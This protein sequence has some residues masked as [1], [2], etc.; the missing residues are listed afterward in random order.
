MD[1]YNI[2]L[3]TDI[4]RSVDDYLTLAYLLTKD[5]CNL[6]GVIISGSNQNNKAKIAS[7]VCTSSKKQ[8]P[9]YLGMDSKLPNNWYLAPI[10][11][12]KLSNWQ[13][14]E[15]FEGNFVDYMYSVIKNNPYAITIIAVGQLTSIAKL[16]EIYPN[17]TAYIKELRIMG[18]V[19]DKELKTSSEMPFI[20]W[21]IWSDPVSAKKV[22]ASG[23]SIIKVYGYEITKDLT[24]TK[25]EFLKR[26]NTDLFKCVTDFS[27][28][29]LNTNNPI[30]NDCLPAVSVFND[31]MCSYKKG[32]IEINLS[33]EPD[34]PL[35]G[36]TTFIEK[37]S[38][39]IELC[40]KVEKDKFFIEYFK[41]IDKFI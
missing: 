27:E 38:G 2:L 17:C 31:E 9:I 16:I 25:E 11:E 15:T 5:N 24:M 32:K 13:H 7:A 34:S 12:E 20:N 6:H 39:N 18:G 40:T 29:W 36:S 41:T 26:T 23:I 14:S 30:F 10:G 28:K 1:Y 19:F 3:D 35:Y 8:V 21:N 37:A 4:G 22:L 33:E